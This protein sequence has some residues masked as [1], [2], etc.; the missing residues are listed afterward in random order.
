MT[1][2]VYP[3]TKSLYNDYLIRMRDLI[4]KAYPNTRIINFPGFKQIKQFRKIDYLWLNWYE[5]SVSH[6]NFR[7]VVKKTIFL[8]LVKL[9][10]IKIVA[11]FHNRKPHE[12]KNSIS[13]KFL[14][15]FTFRM[16]EKIIILS[17][18]SIKILTEIYGEKVRN[19]IFLVP[20]PIY[21]CEPKSYSDVNSGNFKILTIGLI[22]PYKNI[23]LIISLAKN[24]P[25]IQFTIAG[26]V[27][28]EDYYQKIN[29][30]AS[31]IQNI[32]LIPKF[33]T[34]EELDKLIQT[35][36]VMMLPYNT[37]SS[38]N[39]G[40]VIHSICKKINI[41]VPTIG[42]INMLKDASDIYC[43]NYSSNEDHLE[44]LQ[45]IINRVKQ[46]YYNNY[47][48]FKDKAERLYYNLL[49]EQS[50]ENLVNCIRPIFNV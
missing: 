3:S 25:D 45:N 16:S 12:S 49:N 28:D 38:L 11:T 47:E 21:I 17:N 43:Y 1:I 4:L 40:T 48:E 27:S 19:K 34:D 35:H 6:N 39:S 23:E 37:E 5:N 24:N 7:N 9:L 22:R 15:W 26:K 18:D 8:I 50:D 42:T 32:Q 10:R 20:H 31:T 46:E 2:A 30:L 33:L 44:E 36:S 41:I 14:F 29:E 13:A